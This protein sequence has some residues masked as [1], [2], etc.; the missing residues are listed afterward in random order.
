L[1]AEEEKAVAIILKDSMLIN[2]AES[3]FQKIKKIS[4]FL[5]GKIFKSRGLPT[6]SM[7]AL[8][9][10]QQYRAASAGQ[11]IWCGNYAQIFNLF[12]GAAHI[13]NRYIESRQTF[14]NIAGGVHVFN[15][16][17]LAE[18]NKWAAID[19]MFNNVAYVDASGNFLNAVEVKNTQ[20]ANGAISVLQ[21]SSGDSLVSRP[22]AH[23]ETDFF[24]VYGPAKKLYYYYNINFNQVYSFSEKIRRYVSST[25]LV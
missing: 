24:D 14:G 5:Y 20:P 11:A 18:K 25:E 13:K 12:A 1:T 2:E 23:L 6:D 8:G 21:S 7:M 16:Y 9:V 4:D 19:I 15:E 22:F 3:S 10:F 17:W